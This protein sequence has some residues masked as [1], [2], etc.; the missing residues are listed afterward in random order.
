MK[1]F[2]KGAVALLLAIALCFSLAGC[3]D[4]NL[5]WAAKK[6]DTELPVGAYIYYL[7][8]AYN[9]AAAQIGTDTE[10]LKGEVEG[11]P[12]D[13]WIRERAKA[14][15]TQ[16]FWMNDEMARLGL[17][18]TDAD[19]AQ[20]LQ[21]TTSYWTYFGSVFEDYGVAQ[22]SFD[23]AYSQYNVMYLKVFEAL[24]S[25]GGER[26]VPETDIRDYLEQNY[27]SYEYFTAPLTTKAEDESTVEMTDEEKAALKEKL[28]S[29][30]K[31]ILSGKTTVSDAAND[32]ALEI[33]TDSTYQVGI[34]DREGMESSYMP[35]DFI[36]TLEAMKEE[37]VEVFEASGYM[38]LLRRLPIKDSED[39]I[40]ASHDSR[41]NLLVEM[42]NDEFQTSVREAVQG[43]EG[44]ELNQKA[45]NR[46]KP[47][48]FTDTTKNG[49]SSV[50]E[51]SSESSAE[52]SEDS[53]ES[54]AE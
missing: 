35:T 13:E 51:E 4:E 36:D 43:T 53:S 34:N 20:A 12:A 16:Y 21:N 1:R 8:V 26:A 33:E 27:Y 10:V 23:I 29:V 28:E 48:M 52:E 54:S 49:T 6:G 50:P 25:E 37:D 18:M 19:Y 2:A 45:V 7:S 9:E 11:Q 24:Y 5:T 15:V 3:Y 47:S 22:S 31:D 17:E 38:V 46:Y 32:Y 14:Y 44:V 40:L 39:E 41:L 30:K 42:K